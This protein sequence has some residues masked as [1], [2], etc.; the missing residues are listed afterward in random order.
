MILI[1]LMDYLI[2][3]GHI[4]TVTQHT[5]VTVGGLN[6]SIGA[7]RIKKMLALY[8]LL[9]AYLIL[10]DVGA[11]EIKRVVLE[12]EPISADQTSLILVLHV[13]EGT[14]FKAVRVLS[15]QQL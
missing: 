5:S 12:W 9:E 3:Q 2:G 14:S 13:V 15:V 1:D 7:E 8:V 4:Y 11:S 6:G 10:L